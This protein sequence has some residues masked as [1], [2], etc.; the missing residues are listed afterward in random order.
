MGSG[1]EEVGWWVI[2]LRG[3]EESVVGHNGTRQVSTVA[4]HLL[5]ASCYLQEISVVSHV[6][7]YTFIYV[8]Y[9][10]NHSHWNWMLHL[11]IHSI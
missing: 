6:Y 7:K 11:H 3:G 10:I 1:W 9:N 2:L 5:L 8:S 4:H